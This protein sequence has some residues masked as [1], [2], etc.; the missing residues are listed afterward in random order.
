MDKDNNIPIEMELKKLGLDEKEAKVYLV[1]LEFGHAPVQNIAKAAQLSRPTAYRIIES[2]RKKGLVR[3]VKKGKNNLIAAGSPDE[4]LGI[5]RAQKRRIEEQEREFLRIISMLKNKFYFGSR[6]EIKTFSGHEGIQFL[7]N[8]FSTTRSKEIMVAFF[9]QNDTASYGLGSIYK[10]IRKRLGKNIE[11]KE[12]HK[13]EFKKTTSEYVEQKRLL[14]V[15]TSIPGT[16][17]LADKLIYIE[18]NQGIMIEN[19]IV[20]DL[21]R[22]FLSIFWKSSK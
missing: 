4:I 6:N 2:L 8:D 19:E 5:L 22:S 20:V 12:L 9:G 1:C 15:P 3:Q 16:I 14:D 13:K 21:V 7:L 11:V 18:K 10:S 17:I